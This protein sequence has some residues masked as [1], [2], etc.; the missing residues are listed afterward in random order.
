[1]VEAL[2]VPAVNKRLALVVE[3]DDNAAEL[4]RLFLEADGFSVLRASSAEEAL[5]MAPQ[6]S[7]D[8]ITLD[9]QLPGID[10]WEF[11]SAIR[12]DTALS[13]VPVVVISGA[14][15]GQPLVLSGGAAAVL[16]K[17]ISRFALK[18]ALTHLG[19]D[20]ELRQVRTVLVVDD[21][22]RAVEVLAAFLPAPAYVTVRA[23]GG[24]EAI[25]LARRML[26]DLILLDLMMPD[27]DGHDV[28]HALK[29]DP[30]TADIPILIVTAKQITAHDQEVLNVDPDQNILILE[31]T[32]VSHGEFLAE[33]RHALLR[34]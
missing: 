28:V 13:K 17:P 6:H 2:P 20:E 22:P 15:S 4:V 23:Y 21:D 30:E 32:G 11:L 1:M 5:Q 3:D 10:G 9:I 33:V 16:E 26:P 12:E 18:E 8:L 25:V 31:K 34:R 7:L 24:Q 14:T 19:F 29:S 27:V